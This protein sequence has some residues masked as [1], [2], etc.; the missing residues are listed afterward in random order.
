LAFR[1]LLFWLGALFVCVIALLQA[2]HPS[3][4]APARVVLAATEGGK[5]R[6]VKSAGGEIPMPPNTPAA[7]ASTLAPLPANHSSLIA[8]AWFAGERESAPDVRIAFSSFDKAQQR[9]TPARFIAD[10]ESLGKALGFGIRRLGNPVLWRDDDERLHLFV[11]G[12]GLGG[13]ATSRIIHLQQSDDG[14]DAENPRFEA[15]AVLPLS[16]LWNLSYLVRNAPLVL[17]DGAVVLPIYFELGTKYPALARLDRAGNFRGISRISRKGNLLQPALLPVSENRWLAYMRMSAGT[18]RIAIAETKDAG[19]NWQ[20]R[21]DL[22]LPNP[23]ASVA[24]LNADGVHAL[25]FNPSSTGRDRLVTAT[26]ADGERWNISAELA[27][28]QTGDEYSYPAM[29]WHEDTLWVSYTDRRRHIAWQR[30][31]IV[32]ESP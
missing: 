30:F 6:L 4:P 14:T 9:W 8:A 28:G 7:H 23:N 1:H 3:E 13:W 2:T 19:T 26:S 11:V 12:T 22:E 16:W 29:L 25:T 17:A 5:V 31:T 24:A 21:P 10:R 27:L 32:R 15:R 18:H 20:D